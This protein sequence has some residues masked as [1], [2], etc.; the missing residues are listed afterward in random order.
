M[1]RQVSIPVVVVVVGVVGDAMATDVSADVTATSWRL[2]G[3]V[4]VM[5]WL[6]I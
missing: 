4:S 6:S 1:K 5:P 3:F 2:H